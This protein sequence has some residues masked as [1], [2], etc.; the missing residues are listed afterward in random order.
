MKN[1][2]TFLLLISM[3][4]CVPAF[5]QISYNFT[6]I[7]I[8][9]I[10]QSDN[11][12]AEQDATF[13]RASAM[14]VNGENSFFEMDFAFSQNDEETV[15]TYAYRLGLGRHSSLTDTVDIF[16]VI[17]A[18]GVTIDT[19]YYDDTDFEAYFS[20]GIRNQY[21]S[22]TNTYIDG[23]SGI[24]LGVDLPL[25]DS[26]AI[27]FQFSSD[28]DEFDNGYEIDTDVFSIGYKAYM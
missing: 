23:E 15:N 8:G 18:V 12:G 16:G 22:L 6:S 27:N 4:L 25:N 5:S 10:E 7:N 24:I 11:L 28:T 1:L 17:G 2:K 21:I 19:Y 13:F 14:R 20:V 3:V 26:T 9:E